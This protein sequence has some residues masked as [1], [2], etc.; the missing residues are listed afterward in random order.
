[1]HQNFTSRFHSVVLEWSFKYYFLYFTSKQTTKLVTKY[2]IVSVATSVEK[3]SKW[4]KVVLIQTT[5]IDGA[6]V[7]PLKNIPFSIDLSLP[8]FRFICLQWKWIE[9]LLQPTNATVAITYLKN[10]IY[11]RNCLCQTK[12]A[13]LKFVLITFWTKFW[14]NLQIKVR[15]YYVHINSYLSEVS[16]L[17]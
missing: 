3:H 15:Q 2:I 1:M 7:L 10:R 16:F 12:R 6:S 8:I 14:I 4:A 11:E 17:I 13:R 5:C 9:F